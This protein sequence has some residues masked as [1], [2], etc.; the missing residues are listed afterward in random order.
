MDL[1]AI[2]SPRSFLEVFQHWREQITDRPE[3]W[4]RGFNLEAVRRTIRDTFDRYGEGL[5]RLIK[6]SS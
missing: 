2:D 1:S 4:Q 3:L 5:L 6:V